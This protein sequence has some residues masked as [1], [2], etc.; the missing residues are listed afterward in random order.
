MNPSGSHSSLENL[1]NTGYWDGSP[2]QGLGTARRGKFGFWE[3]RKLKPPLERPRGVR[4]VHQNREEEENPQDSST[5]AAPI[6]MGIWG[7]QP[8][9]YIFQRDFH[10]K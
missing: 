9:S 8:P 10:R 7:H 6:V 5:V 2:H 1:V 4:V 3:N